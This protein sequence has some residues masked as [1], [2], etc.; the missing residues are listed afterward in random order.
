MMKAQSTSKKKAVKPGVKAKKAAVKKVIKKLSGKKGE[1]LVRKDVDAKKLEAHMKTSTERTKKQL[2]QYENTDPMRKGMTNGDSK[3]LD[4]AQFEDIVMRFGTEESIDR[5]VAKRNIK[6]LK[7]VKFLGASCLTSHQTTV[8]D[9]QEPY[10]TSC[11]NLK[12]EIPLSELE[13]HK[14]L[15]AINKQDDKKPRAGRSL[16][17][18]LCFVGANSVV[19]YKGVVDRAGDAQ[20]VYRE[21]I[22]IASAEKQV[23]CAKFLI[24]LKSFEN[25]E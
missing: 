20:H 7:T 6:S 16:A 24:S 18:I 15:D 9:G 1:F 22:V 10:K 11:A 3:D 8:D 23:Q 25:I 5:A 21:R 4:L 17:F 12:L 19:S 14:F 2:K 13:G